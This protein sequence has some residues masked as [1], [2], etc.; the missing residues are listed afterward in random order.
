MTLEEKVKHASDLDLLLKS[1]E[2]QKALLEENIKKVTAEREDV[3]TDL[4][5]ET[6]KAN[7]KDQKL[8]DYFLTYFSKEDVTW[9]DDAGLLKKLQENQA[10][11]FIK[12]TTKT[13]TSIDKTALKK[14]FK[15]DENLKQQYKQFYGS[16]MIE[17]VTVTNE[18]NH[19]KMLEHI[20]SNK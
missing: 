18:E 7:I 20:S 17:Y 6:K 10:L 9:L 3:F 12:V 14:A 16:K 13:T 1:L 4:L 15:L 11:Q 5:E 8:G 2:E 19:T